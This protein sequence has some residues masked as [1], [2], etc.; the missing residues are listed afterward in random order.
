MS[1]HG[2]PKTGMSP[3]RKKSKTKQYE[4]V[5]VKDRRQRTYSPSQ[6]KSLFPKLCRID[7]L[8]GTMPCCLIFLFCEIKYLIE[9]YETDYAQSVDCSNL[10][11]AAVGEEYGRQDI[12]V[13]KGEEKKEFQLQY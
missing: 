8:I 13:F 12:C 5:M 1:H 10:L 4:T 9:Q 7:N 11:V 6:E 3:K 2:P